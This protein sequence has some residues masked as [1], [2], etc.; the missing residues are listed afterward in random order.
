MSMLWQFRLMDE[1]QKPKHDGGLG[2]AKERDTNHVLQPM[3][4]NIWLGK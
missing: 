1:V 2:L 4:M 3:V